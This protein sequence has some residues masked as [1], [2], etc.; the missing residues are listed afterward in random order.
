V[1]PLAVILAYGVWLVSL[2]NRVKKSL[3]RCRSSPFLCDYA[4][5]LAGIETELAEIRRF[6]DEQRGP[7]LDELLRLDLKDAATALIAFLDR[8][9]YSTWNAA[10][11]GL[12]LACHLR[13]TLLGDA[14]RAPAPSR[15]PHAGGSDA[16]QRLPPECLSPQPAS[17]IAELLGEPLPAVESK[18]RR[19]AKKYDDC[20]EEIPSPRVN[21]ATVLYR[22]GDVWPLMVAWRDGRRKRLERRTNDG[23]N[24]PGTSNPSPRTKKRRTDNG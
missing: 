18:L 7:A 13:G 10:R 8:P 5:D 9:S 16:A 24:F 12:T 22:M 4:N 15:G 17:A 19:L 2:P 23:R 21:E 20:C 6:I 14:G 3:A 11:D 1:D